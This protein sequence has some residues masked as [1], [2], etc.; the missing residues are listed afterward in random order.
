MSALDVLQLLLHFCHAGNIT[1]PLQAYDMYV[2]MLMSFP[3][4]QQTQGIELSLVINYI[5]IIG[6]LALHSQ[7]TGSIETNL[8]RRDFVGVFRQREKTFQFSCLLE[9]TLISVLVYLIITL[10]IQFIYINHRNPSTIFHPRLECPLDVTREI[11][12][13]RILNTGRYLYH[14]HGIGPLKLCN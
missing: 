10:P 2:F 8:E 4:V 7:Q 3:L 14:A 1:V 12:N 11:N 13:V 5:Y 6:K 9:R